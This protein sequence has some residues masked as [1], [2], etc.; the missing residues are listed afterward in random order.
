MQNIK[1]IEESL[2][3]SDPFLVEHLM[4]KSKQELQEHLNSLYK[5]LSVTNKKSQSTINALQ[6]SIQ[7]TENMI[8]LHQHKEA[9]VGGISLV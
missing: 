3:Q 1:D 7:V 6:H 8:M 9:D 2:Y 5:Q 4:G